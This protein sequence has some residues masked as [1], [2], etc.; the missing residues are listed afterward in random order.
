MKQYLVSALVSVDDVC[1][2]HRPDAEMMKR[3]IKNYCVMGKVNKPLF[4]GRVVMNIKDIQT[5]VKEVRGLSGRE[6]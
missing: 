1:D 6:G 3:L 5:V 2:G 4:R